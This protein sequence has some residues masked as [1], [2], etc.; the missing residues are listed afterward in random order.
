MSIVATPNQDPI[1]MF[2]IKSILVF[3]EYVMCLTI[4]GGRLEIKIILA[5]LTESSEAQIFFPP[6]V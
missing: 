2:C 6:D 3:L 1:Y 5:L 4:G